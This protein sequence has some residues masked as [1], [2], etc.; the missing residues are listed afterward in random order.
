MATVFPKNPGRK[1]AAIE[2]KQVF[3]LKNIREK[4]GK[5][6]KIL[7]KNREKRGLIVER[8]GHFAD[9]CVNGHGFVRYGQ[10]TVKHRN[11]T[12]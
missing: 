4:I 11:K 1:S 2:D 6:P 3:S 12:R 9:I 8:I 10:V 7:H 5:I